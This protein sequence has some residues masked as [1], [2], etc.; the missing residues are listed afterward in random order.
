MI[1][2]RHSISF[3]PIS[4]DPL[5]RL[6]SLPPIARI[7]INQPKLPLPLIL[8]LPKRVNLA[9]EII[10]HTVHIPKLCLPP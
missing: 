6:Q 2:Y 4:N 5:K 3:P 9:D 7:L 10:Q 1:S 8:K